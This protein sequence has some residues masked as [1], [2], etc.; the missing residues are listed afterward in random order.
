M[1]EAGLRRGD[2]KVGLQQKYCWPGLERE[3]VAAG[4]PPLEGET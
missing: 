2:V 3:G 1:I 4:I